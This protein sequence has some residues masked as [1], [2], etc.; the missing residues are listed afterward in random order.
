MDPKHERDDMTEDVDRRDPREVTEETPW[1]GPRPKERGRV[2][3]PH[4]QTDGTERQDP[5]ELVD[6]PDGDDGSSEAG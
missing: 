5:H 1:S 2:H 6:E 3:D 4:E